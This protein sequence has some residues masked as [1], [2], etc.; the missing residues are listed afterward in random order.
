MKGL[1]RK[2][3]PRGRAP[4][5]R[6]AQVTRI[7]IPG[8]RALT[9]WASSSPFI[10]LGIVNVSKD[11]AHIWA[12]VQDHEHPCMGGRDHP[13]A[14][15]LAG[16]LLGKQTHGKLVLDHENG[17]LCLTHERLGQRCTTSEL[18]VQRLA[19]ATKRTIVQA[20]E[21]TKPTPAR[22]QGELAVERWV[23]LVTLL[24][25]A[26]PVGSRSRA[27]AERVVMELTGP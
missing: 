22:S 27:E 7:S 5:Q 9:V 16:D 20:V 2:R 11:E 4:L 1:C 18:F 13:V 24:R 25:S 14:A 8:Q 6:A 26:Q 23:G 17:R 19:S 12:V 21:P 15:I 10:E 3:P